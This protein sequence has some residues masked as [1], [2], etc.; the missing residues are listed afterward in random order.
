MI[1]IILTIYKTTLNGGSLFSLN[2][3]PGAFGPGYETFSRF[4]TRVQNICNSQRGGTKY[5]HPPYLVSGGT[6]YFQKI[7]AYV[8]SPK[9]L[10]ILICSKAYFCGNECLLSEHHCWLVCL[11]IIVE[12]RSREV[13]FRGP[14]RTRISKPPGP[15]SISDPNF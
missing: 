2:T 14:T 13:I 4:L 10:T 6:K 8:T 9:I 12:G 11:K 1:L 5:L 3:R 15:E 7:P